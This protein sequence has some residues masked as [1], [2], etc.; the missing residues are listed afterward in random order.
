MNNHI[1][2]E[3]PLNE[4][5]RTLLR[6]EYLFRLADHHL[7]GE[8]EWDVRSLIDSLL[9]VTD[10]IS[11]TDIKNEVIKELERHAGVFRA[12]QKNPGVDPARLGRLLEDIQGYLDKLRDTYCL[13]GQSLKQNELINSIRQ[14]N[15]ISGGTCNFDLPAYHQWLHKPLD[16][17]RRFIE[18]W[19]KDLAVIRNSVL[20]VLGLIRGSSNPG[21]ETATR[22][23]FQKSMEQNSSCQLIRVV[24]P[25]D[26]PYYPEISA[27][28]HRVTI[29]FM[30]Q[31]DT[32]SRP[33]QTDT[34]VEFELHCCLL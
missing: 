11:R 16:V 4:R 17:Q 25:S 18:E 22:G 8:S 12:L 5:I 24:M 9:D 15:A 28:K 23:F 20:L 29:R 10:L 31:A 1:T 32:C 33:V 27:G 2:Y 7:S 3:Q 30:E 14:R 34:D 6:L 21:T 19:Q 26:S 13:P